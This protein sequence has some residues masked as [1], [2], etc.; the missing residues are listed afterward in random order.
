MNEAESDGRLPENYA[1][2]K[3]ALNE[4]AKAQYSK[5]YG[6]VG[7]H[8][9]VQICLWNRKSIQGHRGCYK[10]K[11][12]GIDCHRC[13]QMSPALAWCSEACVFCWRPMEWMKRISFGEGEVDE[14]DLIIAETVKAR[15]K[16]V[17]GIKGGPK[18]DLRKFNEAFKLFPSHWAISL[19]GEPTIYPKL[20]GM[21]K[22]LKENPEVKTIFLVTNGQEPERL[23]QLAK[24]D[25]LPTQLYISLAAPNEALFQKINRSVHKD[26]WERLNRS[27]ELIAGLPCR[28]VIRLTVIRG[29]ND[30][31]DSL[32][33][34][35]ALIS[36]SRADF[37]EVKSYMALGFSRKRLGPDFM[38]EHE[39]VKQFAE[40]LVAAMPDYRIEDED[41]ISRI[42]LLKRKDTGFGNIIRNK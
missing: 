13:A 3:I 21:I 42:V 1:R 34:Y 23:S 28:R 2:G 18:C 33:G 8:S 17:S 14:P 32:A 24:D 40:K 35:A 16:L 26:G 7:N 25:A 38:A 4:A 39:Q 11:F 22:K 9:G 37:V 5:S 30:A 41:A 6:L 29:L 15:K 27:L 20:G 12:Y 10:V 36:K 19:S 31:D